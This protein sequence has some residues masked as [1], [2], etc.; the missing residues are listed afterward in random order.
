MLGPEARA[1]A[2]VAR[3]VGRRRAQAEDFAGTARAGLRV[4]AFPSGRRLIG[5]FGRGRAR[6]GCSDRWTAVSGYK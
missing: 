3:R 5:G 4:G 1:R 2:G 6:C